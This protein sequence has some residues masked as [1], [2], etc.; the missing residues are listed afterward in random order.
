MTPQPVVRFEFGDYALFPDEKVL[1][2]FNKPLSIP[3]KGFEILSYLVQ[4]A[5]SFVS[6]KEIVEYVWGPEIEVADSN[7]SHL[8]AKIRKT[9]GCDARR[10]RFIRTVYNKDGYRFITTVRKSQAT[11]DQ[12]QQVKPAKG[13]HTHQLTSHLF[14]PVFLGK[15]AF[16]KLS[17]PETRNDWIEYKVRQT[18]TGRLC[19]SGGGF[20][21]WHLTQK[22]VVHDVSTIATWRKQTYNEILNRKH[23]IA[24]RTKEILKSIG[25]DR[26]AEPEIGKFGYVFSVVQLE[27][28]SLRRKESKWN[29]LKILANL[30]LLEGGLTE[31][32]EIE[33]RE[34]DLL[35]GE[36]EVRDL[37]EFGQA[38]I[39]LGFAGWDGVSYFHSEDHGPSIS[40]KLVE[41]EITVQALWWACKCLRDIRL[42]DDPNDTA[43][44]SDLA[45]GIRRNYSQI[46]T[47]LARESPSQRSMVE[48]V[49]NTSR[50]KQ[51]VEGALDDN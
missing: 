1:L 14:V 38:G 5:N 37:D 4:H 2:H 41:F 46:R 29:L 33:Q 11:I 32:A 30:S 10:P 13:S 36:I 23:S 7:M 9:I 28:T 3:G 47:I 51:M 42:A 45:G 16:P 8:I 48:A 24:S 44:M 39:D 34:M 18:E 31:T 17:L 27:G 25:A 50:I 40:E 19:L 6:K 15:D 35:S 49:L 22:H 26:S 20:G 43:R 21:V 12:V